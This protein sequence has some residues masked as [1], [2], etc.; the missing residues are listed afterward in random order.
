MRL[1]LHRTSCVAGRR[2]VLC[3]E[4]AGLPR[5]DPRLQF[6]QLKGMADGLSLTLAL[7]RYNVS[8]YLPYGKVEEV[9]PYLLRRAQ[10]NRGVLGNTK[11][12]RK[13][14]W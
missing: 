2:A 8:K 7:S 10:E 9:M 1:F 3:A 4:E 6:A 11:D 13:R 14:I 5:T 12:E